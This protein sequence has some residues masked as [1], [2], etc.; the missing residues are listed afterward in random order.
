M[1]KVA[2]G[3]VLVI[4]PNEF[5][6]LV[7]NFLHYLSTFVSPCRSIL[8]LIAVLTIFGM[9]EYTNLSPLI[10]QRQ[11]AYVTWTNRCT[12]PKVCRLV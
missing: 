12:C 3:L 11:C 6:P 9:L 10:Y 5:M 1:Y 2:E 7:N 4:P 8:C